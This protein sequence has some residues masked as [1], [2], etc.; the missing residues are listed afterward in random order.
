MVRTVDDLNQNPS[1]II[2]RSPASSM[3][4]NTVSIQYRLRYAVKIDKR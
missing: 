2:I 4:V 1:S 3:N